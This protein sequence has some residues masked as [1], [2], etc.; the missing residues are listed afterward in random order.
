MPGGG[1]DPNGAQYRLPPPSNPVHDR[2]ALQLHHVTQALGPYAHGHPD[3]ALNIAQNTNGWM[4]DAVAETSQKIAGAHLSFNIAQ[5]AAEHY[6]NN[7]EV[8]Q[9]FDSYLDKYHNPAHAEPSMY[10]GGQPRFA[11]ATG[12]FAGSEG[13]DPDQ[14]G[15]APNAYTGEPAILQPSAAQ[16]DVI[17]GPSAG[18]RGGIDAHGGNTVAE[19]GTAAKDVGSAL[20]YG[21]DSTADWAK[22]N[23]SAT[24]LRHEG[25]YLRG[26][27]NTANQL[28]NSANP[29]GVVGDHP[30]NLWSWMGDSIA[31]GARDVWRNA[32]EHQ[33]ALTPAERAA[34]RQW[35]YAHPD[36]V[37]QYVK[38]E[39]QNVGL[40][41]GKAGSGS[42]ISGGAGPVLAE[43]Q[44]GMVSP[45]DIAAVHGTVM[46]IINSQFDNLQHYYRYTVMMYRKE[47]VQGLEKAL[48]PALMGALGGAALSLAAGPEAG[49]GVEAAALDTAAA[50]TGAEAAG[51]AAG[52][53]A[54]TDAATAAT[55]AAAATPTE[56]AGGVATPTFT[57]GSDAAGAT[58]IEMTP[59]AS[60][61]ASKS[62]SA[63]AFLDSWPSTLAKGVGYVAKAI[64]FST[65][66]YPAVGFNYAPQIFHDAT[67]WRES[68]KA[69]ADL[70]TIGR[71]LSGLLFK[72]DK[73]T[74][75]SGIVDGFTALSEGPMMLGRAGAAEREVLGSTRSLVGFGPEE[76]LKMA[77]SQG[78]TSGL[79]AAAKLNR[80]RNTLSVI[81][82]WGSSGDAEEVAGKIIGAYQSLAPIA[83]Q[84]ADEAVK[85]GSSADTLALRVA[86]MID[87]TGLV[88]AVRMPTTGLYGWIKSAKVGDSW[89]AHQMNKLFAQTGLTY[90]A[91]TGIQNIKDIHLGD[92]NSLNAI[93][94]W[95]RQTGRSSAEINA[96]LGHLAYTKDLRAW[97]HVYVNSV[98]ENFMRILNQ[99]YV[100]YA[101]NFLEKNGDKEA[102][103]ALRNEIKRGGSTDL[104]ENLFRT[105]EGK[106]NAAIIDALDNSLKE[107]EPLYAQI[108]KA[109]H[110]KV[111]ELV[112]GT[113]A[114]E[115]A[116]QAFNKG[117]T[118]NSQSL[119]GPP[120]SETTISGGIFGT[121]RNPLRLPGYRDFDTQLDK[122]IK[123]LN[124]EHDVSLKYEE[125]VAIQ[126][127]KRGGEW[128]NKWVNEMFFKPLALLTPGWALRVSMSELALNT[129]RI[130]PK[131]MFAGWLTTRLVNGET[132]YLKSVE[133]ALSRELKDTNIKIK[134]MQSERKALID[135]RAE[136]VAQHEKNVKNLEQA[137]ALASKHK[138]MLD[139]LEARV[140]KGESIAEERLAQARSKYEEFSAAKLNYE[141]QVALS[142]EVTT[143]LSLT[144][145]NRQVTGLEE[146]IAQMQ[147]KRDYIKGVRYVRTP[148]P[149]FEQLTKEQVPEDI[150]KQAVKPAVD[151]HVDKLTENIK[152]LRF[153]I[154]GTSDANTRMDLQYELFRSLL[155]RNYWQGTLEMRV[156]GKPPSYEQ[157]LRE[158]V[159][160]DLWKQAFPRQ[161]IS[162]AVQRLQRRPDYYYQSKNAADKALSEARKGAL[163]ELRRTQA[164]IEG[165]LYR[166]FGI[167][168]PDP[169]KRT[170]QIGAPRVEPVMDNTGKH[171]I[172]DANGRKTY[173]IANSY[174]GEHDWLE[175]IPAAERDRWH[176]DGWMANSLYKGNPKRG[177]GT[178]IDNIW[179]TYNYATGRQIDSLDKA[180]S[181]DGIQELRHLID[182]HG[183][184]TTLRKGKR[185]PDWATADDIQ[186]VDDFR[187][188]FSQ[189][190]P[191]F[192]LDELF[193]EG[194]RAKALENVMSR[195]SPERQYAK[196]FVEHAH[197][198]VGINTYMPW[199]MS[200]QDYQNE[201]RRLDE[202]L[203]TVD[204]HPE[205]IPTAEE[206][207]LQR[208]RDFLLNF[209][210]GKTYAEKH[211]YFVKQARLAGE[212]VPLGIEAS[213][214]HAANPTEEAAA[215]Q[216]PE[217]PTPKEGRYRAR[218]NMREGVQANFQADFENM[219]NTK[220]H[221]IHE[222]TKDA[223]AGLAGTKKYGATFSAR[224]S[225][226][227]AIEDGLRERD[228]K[229]T[230]TQME[231]IKMIVRGVVAGATEG[232]LTAI[233]AEEFAKASA[234]LTLK[235]YEH[236]GF[237]PEVVSA[238]EQPVMYD[239]DLSRSE[240]STVNDGN[241]KT[242]SKM[243]TDL[244]WQMT[245]K[246]RAS[247]WDGLHTEASMIAA[248]DLIGRP[249]AK[250]YRDLWYQG[251][252]GGD[253][254][255]QATNRIE[256]LIESLP[257]DV[258][259]TFARDTLIGRHHYA[260][261]GTTDY[262]PHRSW[263]TDVSQQIHAQIAWEKKT[264]KA[265]G[266]QTA[267]YVYS[268]N[269]EKMLNALADNDIAPHVND[270]YKDFGFGPTGKELNTNEIPP[271]AISRRPVND[272]FGTPTRRIQQASTWAHDK[273][274]GPMVDYL[275]RNPTYVYEFARVRQSLNGRVAQG[276]MT[277]DQADVVAETT[278]A[279]RMIRFVHNP[280]DKTKFEEMMRTVAPFYFAENQAW[281]RMGRLFS[282][283]PGAFFQYVTAMYG[284]QK[285]VQQT[286]TANGL[287]VFNIPGMAMYGVPLTGSLSSLQTMD[288]FSP[289]ADATAGSSNVQTF[290]DM[291]VPRFGPVATIT[292][293]ALQYAAQHF[294]PD[295]ERN[296]W[297]K[298]GELYT[299]GGIA[300]SQDLG[301]FAWNTMVPNSL[302][303]NIAD[304]FVGSIS[305]MSDGPNAWTNSYLQAWM[306]AMRY[307]ISSRS[308]QEWDRL[309]KKGE[310]GLTRAEDFYQWQQYQWNQNTPEGRSSYTNLVSDAHRRAGFLW[311]AKMV[312]GLVSPVS[313]GTGTADSAMTKRFQAEVKKHGYLKGADKFLKAYPWA[314]VDTL[315]KTKAT[316]PGYYPPTK[317]MYDWMEQNQDWIKEHPAAALAMAPDMSHQ[318]AYYQPAETL[319][320]QLG[321]RQKVSPKE[322]FDNFEI[323]TGN[324][325]YYNWIR[326]QYERYKEKNP[327]NHAAA[328][329][330]KQDMLKWYGVNHNL[331]WYNHYM[332]ESSITARQHAVDDLKSVLQLPQF[333][334]TGR[335][336]VLN[337]MIAYIY[338][339]KDSLYNQAQAAIKKGNSSDLVRQQWEAVMHELIQKNP[340]CKQA[341]MSMFYNLG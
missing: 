279:Q 179:D 147:S 252:R 237:K 168:G 269:A 2:A 261:D 145:H 48:A 232:M 106:V 100:D 8:A 73:N 263:A 308:Q 177:A 281:R 6:R 91:K 119:L 329:S 229:V 296:K 230:P 236:G 43:I 278:A 302:A 16:Q 137:S 102:A 301:Q 304:G 271:A 272:G 126:A 17:G 136:R 172:K 234:Y 294:E 111:S 14:T 28:I 211:A 25:G 340:E 7:T 37:K 324:S 188:A 85:K 26:A 86:E 72:G 104:G 146:Q 216:M 197:Q 125:H 122:L 195:I 155:E 42:R 65:S 153:A 156:F 103:R 57:A 299:E 56:V 13:K 194:G 327:G 341:I 183:I 322:F 135:E 305:S 55:T 338:E 35:A 149:T 222:A 255:K 287:A 162:G 164:Y 117:M 332:S 173:K 192:T 311:I 24:G 283:N 280:S 292:V 325:F 318:T 184:I 115:K 298:E 285:W 199:E 9:R 259:S 96:V 11:D 181:Q 38:N 108:N 267:E 1:F 93:G 213:S 221:E 62:L 190:K 68:Q 82:R 330:W 90:D 83:T 112:G 134:D 171:F 247:Y 290:I 127:I 286:T 157:L 133:D 310:R 306:E 245:E 193:G 219:I 226:E 22:R 212:D 123:T 36:L 180:A 275:S 31:H 130:G 128:L 196:D 15:L 66:S 251:L 71:G 336:T 206:Q 53:A 300:Q 284:V 113:G 326:P 78:G 170:F 138:N 178:P 61:I 337:Q 4:P 21:A 49:V 228:Y 293:K 295:W 20:K 200:L 277:A 309:G 118:G 69:T 46:K 225:L 189:K 121:H 185:L 291:V 92:V 141:T 297:V 246:G 203:L 32:V 151:E 67:V 144:T 148:D 273:V 335:A 240:M 265:T 266:D 33:D 132:R 238:R 160:E 227:R 243:R 79:A 40:T 105:K 223:R 29:V 312:V 76:F 41:P 320:L 110:E 50:A 59:A 215:E 334:N 39:T 210:E 152:N 204:A 87:T 154:D 158:S 107:L 89:A 150:W 186:A 319:M 165:E 207:E 176:R 256:Q 244:R 250:I 23:L 233:G 166:L 30:F 209:A 120:D 98:H 217:R 331:T 10:G 182:V 268:A 5:W 114:S 248:D 12:T 307:E 258:R 218:F 169:E 52:T 47:G 220:I 201:I 124:K 339:D 58:T 187:L 88:E 77:G 262:T 317:T 276:F 95:M 202:H 260:A 60:E 270:F 253:L 314:T 321:L 81:A 282:S 257:D 289:S 161:R 64:D 142:Q 264:V 174:A 101:I 129:V 224:E 249:A 3:V 191:E 242:K 214:I 163:D 167:E 235:N 131:N 74:P 44:A 75:L 19:L 316:Q 159:G 139:R 63:R 231:N 97:E 303:R 70:S 328:Y 27:T 45:K 80:V 205:L 109:V 116:E 323:A 140:A 241:L 54:A 94:Q 84:L 18:L 254:E 34:N 274:L 239:T 208:R 99:K 143:D 198:Q 313:V 51:T 315:Y 333:R 175:Q 288:P